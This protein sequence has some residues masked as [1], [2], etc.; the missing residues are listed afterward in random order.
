MI[1]ELIK[2]SVIHLN[3]F[4]PKRRVSKTMIP[5]TITTGTTLEYNTHCCIPFGK[6]K[7]MHNVPNP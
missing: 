4:T 2:Q 6:Y 3:Y 5:C 7:K 1:S